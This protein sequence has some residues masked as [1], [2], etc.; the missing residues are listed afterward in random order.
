ME[1]V[2]L[3]ILS[4]MARRAGIRLLTKGQSYPIE[5]LHVSEPGELLN[6]IR[7]EILSVLESTPAKPSGLANIEPGILEFKT[8]YLVNYNIHQDFVTSVGRVHSIH[9]DKQYI[10]VNAIDGRVIDSDMASFV[11][12][13]W[14]REGVHPGY[15]SLKVARQEFKLDSQS[16]LESAK[17]HIVNLN[18]ET[19]RYSGRNN[20][21]YSKVCKPSEK[22]VHITNVT[23][24]YYPH[25]RV[26]IRAL[27]HSYTLTA[28][29]NREHV[30]VTSTNMFTCQECRG[31]V[32][33]HEA[34]L[35]C[36]SCG[37]VVHRKK[38]HGFVCENCEKT[39]CR[40]CTF[41]TR[42][43]LIL[44][45]KLCESCADELVKVGKQKLKLSPL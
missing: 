10:L 28:I 18:T 7:A 6:K 32:Q 43:W 2:D 23:Q 4:E 3:P 36:N 38:S 30:H 22:S 37:A 25:W 19:V 31:V 15:D 35:L 9:A 5:T 33:Q 1:L 45:K 41:W 24:V 27:K 12:A 42:K 40:S 34:A 8:A 13:S 16:L 14:G 26:A 29:E 21:R 20:R 17:T 44:K 39:V 11:L